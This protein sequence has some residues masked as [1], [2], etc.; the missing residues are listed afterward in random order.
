MGAHFMESAV[1]WQ[2]E[3]STNLDFYR[4]DGI[5]R[6]QFVQAMTN[7]VADRSSKEF[8]KIYEFLMHIF[9]EETAGAYGDITFEEF[10][11]ILARFFAPM[12]HFGLG[13][14]E[15]SVDESKAV[16]DSLCEVR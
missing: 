15:M 5:T 12:R 3:S 1:E 11:R 7:A 4:L 2:R 16:F 14:A 8:A 6:E 13:P 9:V 10:Q